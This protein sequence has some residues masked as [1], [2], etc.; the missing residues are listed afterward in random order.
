MGFIV[1]KLLRTQLKGFLAWD[2]SPWFYFVQTVRLA[3]DTGRAARIQMLFGVLAPYQVCSSPR[4]L[5]LV[6][7]L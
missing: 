6:M 7:C 1:E 5:V 2:Y 4:P 3:P